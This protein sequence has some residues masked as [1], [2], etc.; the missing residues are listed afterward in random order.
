MKWNL[1]HKEIQTTTFGRECRILGN[2]VISVYQ[3]F[4]SF[5]S[6]NNEKIN[7]AIAESGFMDLSMVKNFLKF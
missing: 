1:E 3:V 4:F 6:L 5:L 7:D 2:K